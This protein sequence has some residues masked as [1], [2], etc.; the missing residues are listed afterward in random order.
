MLK[1]FA[2]V[3]CAPA[4]ACR[5]GCGRG[6]GWEW[7]C[8]GVPGEGLASGRKPFCPPVPSE[9][10]LTCLQNG[11]PGL[12]VTPWALEHFIEKQSVWRV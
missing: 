10:H 7:V 6:A 3:P 4:W 12:T 1:G 8:L 11:L 5:L 9:T 2:A